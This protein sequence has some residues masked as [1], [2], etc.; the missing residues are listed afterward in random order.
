MNEEI[1]GI[2]YSS[3]GGL[4]STGDLMLVSGLDNAKQAIHNRLLT[5][6]IIY[7]YLDGYG[8]DLDEIMGEATNHN[9]L[10]LLELIVKESLN[11]E[12]RVQ[13]ILNLNIYFENRKIIAEMSL[14]LVDG[15]VLDLNVEY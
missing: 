13:S 4:T 10:Q 11:L 5:R 6:I 15:S 2:D 9:S 7:D 12:P 8:C 14:K 1:F 3:N